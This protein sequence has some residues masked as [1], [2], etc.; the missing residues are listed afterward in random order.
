[1]LSNLHHLYI[2]TN[3]LNGKQYVGQAMH[4]RQR[5]NRH[6]ADA[7]K[8]KPRLAIQWAIKKY[9]SQHF[10]FE[11]IAACKTPDDANLTEETLIMQLNTLNPNGYNIKPGG[12]TTSPNRGP[13]GGSFKLG[14]H[15]SPATEFKIGRHVRTSRNA[16]VG[17]SKRTE[18]EK[19]YLSSLYKNRSWKLIDGK[20]V[21]K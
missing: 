21:W 20:R 11:V 18:E 14:E 9:G 12:Q 10:T 2:I 17:A 13:N 6:K 15:R 19:S 3:T 7:Q 16:L 8:E 5:W 1:M 4:P